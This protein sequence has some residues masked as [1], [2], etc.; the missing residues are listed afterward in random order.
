MQDCTLR[1][2]IGAG[3]RKDELYW[4]RG[5]HNTQACH[6]RMENQLTH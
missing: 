4:Y 5:V 3:E 2:L 1:T 6:V